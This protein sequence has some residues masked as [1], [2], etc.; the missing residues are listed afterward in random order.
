[1]ISAGEVKGV[2][3]AGPTFRLVDLEARGRDGDEKFTVNYDVKSVVHF[4]DG[5]HSYFVKVLN[6]RIEGAQQCPA[7]T[8]YSVCS[9]P[10][11][12][13]CTI[14]ERGNIPEQVQGRRAEI[15]EVPVHELEDIASHIDSYL[16]ED[17]PA[18]IGHIRGW[19]SRTGSLSITIP[20]RSEEMAMYYSDYDGLLYGG[21]ECIQARNEFRLN[22]ATC[23]HP[24]GSLISPN[25]CYV[26]IHDSDAVG[27]F[28]GAQQQTHPVYRITL[29]IE[30]NMNRHLY[31]KEVNHFGELSNFFRFYGAFGGGVR[32]YSRFDEENDFTTAGLSYGGF[33]HLQRG[34]VALNKDPIFDSGIAIGFRPAVELGLNWESGWLTSLGHLNGTIT[35]AKPGLGWREKRN[36][37]LDV[38]YALRYLPIEDST[39]LDRGWTLGV[40]TMTTWGPFFRFFHFPDAAEETTASIGID[41]EF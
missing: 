8:A 2:K 4:Y 19:C 12:T 14:Y 36:T 35:W 31:R 5:K 18:A 37:T 15:L 41:A 23:K 11:S 27:L 29:G 13:E 28:S 1:M 16:Q 32:L 26:R 38:G 3:E 10:A 17:R 21:S 24:D 20:G 34:V 22:S 40:S 33:Y 25:S 6:G 7:E 9:G 30:E 39:Q